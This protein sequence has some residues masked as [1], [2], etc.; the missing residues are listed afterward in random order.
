[1]NLKLVQ[2]DG[3]AEGQPNDQVV[4]ETDTKLSKRS[5]LVIRGPQI[6][7]GQLL[8]VLVVQ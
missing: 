3:V 1:V 4:L 2:H 7:S 6:G 5:P 8:L